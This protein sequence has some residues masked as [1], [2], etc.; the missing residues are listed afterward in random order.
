MNDHICFLYL[1]AN[2]D[3]PYVESDVYYRPILADVPSVA[4]VLNGLSVD[5]V[6]PILLLYPPETPVP[7]F[8]GLNLLLGFLNPA[9]EIFSFIPN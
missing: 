5:A 9:P 7:S 1:I 8:V 2:I 6:Y 3:L 4:W